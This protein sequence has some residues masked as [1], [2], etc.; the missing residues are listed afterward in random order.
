ML[1]ES[2]PLHFMFKRI[3]AFI[4][5]GVTL[6]TSDLT[7]T[8]N[9]I[10]TSNMDYTALTTEAVTFAANSATSDTVNLAILPDMLVEGIERLLVSITATGTGY[11][12]GEVDKAIVNI[13]DDD[14]DTSS[15]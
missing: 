1:S 3:C 10:A 5:Q 15:E 11:A 2:G 4:L 9:E 8:T 14:I 6:T 12:V 13:L 7:T